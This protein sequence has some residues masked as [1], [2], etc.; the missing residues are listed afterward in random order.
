[1]ALKKIV[2]TIPYEDQGTLVEYE[3]GTTELI[4][5]ADMKLTGQKLSKEDEQSL[6]KK[7]MQQMKQ[8]GMR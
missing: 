6:L 2:K 5:D 7:Y 4:E 3:D 1:M 8:R